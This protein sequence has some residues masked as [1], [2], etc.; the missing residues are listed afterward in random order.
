MAKSFA[1][2]SILVQM[3][4]FWTFVDASFMAAY[5]MFASLRSVP[6]TDTLM[7]KEHEKTRRLVTCDEGVD[8]I[9]YSRCFNNLQNCGEYDC[10]HS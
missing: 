1:L 4:P 8:M 3:P 5:V 2:G 9:F 7:N 6:F 10:S